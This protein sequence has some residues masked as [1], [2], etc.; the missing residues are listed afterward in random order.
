MKRPPARGPVQIGSSYTAQQEVAWY[1]WE[2]V[3]R[4]P[5]FCADYNEFVG[6]FG[7]WLKLK[8]AWGSFGTPGANWSKSDKKYFR[9]QIEPVLDEL[10]RKWRVFDLY[11][12]ALD[13]EEVFEGHHR[14][15]FLPTWLP[16][17]ERENS[18]SIRD[19]KDMG[20]MG[21]GRMTKMYENLLLMQFDLNSPMKDLLEHAESTLR[22]ARRSYKEEMG[23]QGVRL[24]TGRRRFE[25]YDLHLEVWDL[26]QQGKPNTEIATLVFPKYSSESALSRVRDHL[27]AANKLISGRYREIS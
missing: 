27:K 16:A 11:P 17:D 18:R 10:C 2:F 15:L 4:N 9:T 1:R 23:K 25:D 5:K 7:A 20:F 21:K 26:K 8:G 19:I 6:S 3:R 24:Q 12:P 14:E 13:M 22:H